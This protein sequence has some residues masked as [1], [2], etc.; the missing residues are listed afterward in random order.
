MNIVA[1]GKLY[2]VSEGGVRH[3]LKAKESVEFPQT[4][5]VGTLVSPLQ[6]QKAFIILNMKTKQPIPTKPIQTN[7][8]P[9]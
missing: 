7:E 5:N 3:W 4:P 2:F 9:L 6:I 8:V 1:N